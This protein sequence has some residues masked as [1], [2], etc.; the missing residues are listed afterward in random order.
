MRLEVDKA[1]F[2]TSTSCYQVFFENMPLHQQQSK[3]FTMKSRSYF[4][5][6]KIVIFSQH[7]ILILPLVFFPLLSLM[8][9][10]IRDL[11]I[12]AN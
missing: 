1:Y 5:T 8:C 11:F 10:R 4:K 9:V 2:D 6:F 12:K 3:I 7:I